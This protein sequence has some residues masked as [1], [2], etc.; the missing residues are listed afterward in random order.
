MKRTRSMT[1]RSSVGSQATGA[2]PLRGGVAALLLLLPMH[3]CVVRAASGQAPATPPAQPPSQTPSQPAAQTPSQPA[4]QTPAQPAVKPEQP[5]P[6]PAEK[7][8]PPAAPPKSLDDLLGIPKTNEK[9]SGAPEGATGKPVTGD[10]PSTKESRERLARGLSEQE[11]DSL[12]KQALSG[13]RTSVTQ[14]GERTDTGLDTQRVQADV[15]AKLD[16]LIEEAKRRSKGGS[17]SSGSSSSSGDPSKGSGQR[18][19]GEGDPS[20]AKPGES[21]TRDGQRGDAKSGENAGEEPPEK[22]DPNAEQAALD[23]TQSEWGALPERVRDLIR[24]GSRDRV[25]SLYQRL[26]QEYYRRMAEDASR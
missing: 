6:P 5:P 11:L 8:P 13:M 20:G 1:T 24:Q 17:P 18:Q 10:D 7:T 4:A 25:A 23:E 22:V 26:T 2:T 14:L 9:P 15:V 16:Q 21:Q 3:A 19:P 12:L